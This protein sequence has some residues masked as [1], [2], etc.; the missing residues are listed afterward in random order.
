MAFYVATTNKATIEK[1]RMKVDQE[2]TNLCRWYQQL[3]D[4]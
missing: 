3:K 1:G 4:T 2:V